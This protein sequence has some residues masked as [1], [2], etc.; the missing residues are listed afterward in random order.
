MLSCEGAQRPQNGRAE[1]Q[2]RTGR[3]TK[4]E[5]EKQDEEGGGEC[6]GLRRTEE[7]QRNFISNPRGAGR[8]HTTG[9]SQR[10]RQRLG[11]SLQAGRAERQA[12]ERAA[13]TRPAGRCA[14][15][16][17]GALRPVTLIP[18]G[19]TPSTPP[20][21]GGQQRLLNTKRHLRNVTP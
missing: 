18:P 3:K 21:R 13:W 12:A 9:H 8:R 7:N 5:P 14:L 2:R 16:E 11:K 20:L 19:L 6:W 1:R 4:G 15:G 17:H 10:P